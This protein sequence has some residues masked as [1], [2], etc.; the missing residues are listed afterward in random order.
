MS[1][2]TRPHSMVRHAAFVGDTMI[3]TIPACLAVGVMFM[4]VAGGYGALFGA[5][6]AP[7]AAVMIARVLR[8]QRIDGRVW[9]EAA[10]AGAVV[11]VV[12]AAVYGAV[13]SYSFDTRAAFGPA[14]AVLLALEGMVV[15]A[16]AV[17]A[18]TDLAR[19]RVHQALDI[20]R[21]VSAALVVVLVGLFA[22][23]PDVAE[24][25]VFLAPVALMGAAAGSLADLISTIFRPEGDVTTHAPTPVG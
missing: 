14:M 17:D 6:I 19:D 13:V 2:E 20:V 15:I 22:T 9:V 24:A 23:G 21:L 7:I 8:G 10:A 11:A 3:L 18:V 5:V 16:M 12:A 1:T 4:G 25:L